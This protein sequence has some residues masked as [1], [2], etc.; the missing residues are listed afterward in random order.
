MTDYLN[1]TAMI[2]DTDTCVK[3]WMAE[4]H[5]NRSCEDNNRSAH[6]QLLH[7]NLMTYPLPPPPSN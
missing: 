3:V 2:T 6:L 7:E 5:H 4:K 1:P